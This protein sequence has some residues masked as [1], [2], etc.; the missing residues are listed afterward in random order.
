MTGRRSSAAIAAALVAALVVS[1]AIAADTIEAVT[2]PRSGTLTVCRDWLVYDSCST[3]HHVGLPDRIAV[4][5]KVE[6]TYG[7]NPKDYIFHVTGIRRHGDAC[8]L[9]SD[10]SGPDGAGEKIE[11][12]ACQ[13]ATNPAAAR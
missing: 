9:L 2:T 5:D 13:P 10:R 1:G 4:G 3:Y 6:L 11:I 8:T 12:A 7:S